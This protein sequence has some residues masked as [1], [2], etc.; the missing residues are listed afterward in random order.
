[1][2]VLFWAKEALTQ[3]DGLAY[4]IDK[5]R[6]G[7]CKVRGKSIFN[8]EFCGK[9]HEFIQYYY[10]TDDI[11]MRDIISNYLMKTFYGR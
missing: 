2:R 7:G 6:T 10:R 3:L 1:M 4:I 11:M 9:F 5:V 8:N